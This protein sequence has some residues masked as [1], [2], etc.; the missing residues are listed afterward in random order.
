MFFGLLKYFCSSLRDTL[1][2]KR[3]LLCDDVLDDKEKYLCTHC[4]HNYIVKSVQKDEFFAP[5]SL[6]A[7]EVV[8]VFH[9]KYIEKA[10]K[11]FKFH[12]QVSIGK[13]L[14]KVLAQRLQQEAWLKEIDYIVPVPLHRTAQHKRQFN[15]C[16]VIADVLGKDLG[17][18]VSKS[19]LYRI[20]NNKP[21]HTL[22]V[23]E[24]YKNVESNF[25][26]KDE[27]MFREKKIL[28]VD[29]VITTC[30]TLKACCKAL[31]KSR[32]TKIYI[33]AISSSRIRF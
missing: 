24:R 18:P 25:S 28:L 17:I 10:I 5:L 30:S 2:P 4:R 16:E 6:F 32:D 22:S 33:S 15:Q 21:Q 14:A 29:D 20:K 23:E 9:Y 27:G 1:F 13:A 7:E 26:L 3:C 19:N 8:V 31:Q 12:R 11:S